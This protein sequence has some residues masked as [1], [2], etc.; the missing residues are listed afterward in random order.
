MT[1]TSLSHVLY[2]SNRV[3]TLLFF[4]SSLITL[5][6]YL[7]EN[8]YL[9]NTSVIGMLFLY[10][11]ALI[12]SNTSV[13]FIA[14]I[15]MQLLVLF[16]ASFVAIPKVVLDIPI[17]IISLFVFNRAVIKKNLIVPNKT[18]FSCLIFGI[19]LGHASYM[20]MIINNNDYE[21]MF[22]KT[23]EDAF[24][25]SD[26]KNITNS[27]Y[28][29][30]FNNHDTYN[31]TMLEYYEL[32]DSIK[33][34]NMREGISLKVQHFGTD[35]KLQMTNTMKVCNYST[36]HNI[37]CIISAYKDNLH[38]YNTYVYTND[39]IENKHL[40]GF[41]VTIDIYNKNTVRHR[42]NSILNNGGFV[43][44][45]KGGWYSSDKYITNY[46]WKQVTNEYIDVANSLST[47]N[48][49]HIIATHDYY[50]RKKINIGNNTWGIFSSSFPKHHQ[51]NTAVGIFYG[52]VIIKDISK[53]NLLLRIL[54][55]RTYGF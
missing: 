54:S 38:E 36:F 5:L 17:F 19:L 39:N 12:T 40:L 25:W 2:K 15:V 33:K 16:N 13:L 3:L 20:A 42:I 49:K 8:V 32:I 29:Y 47:S 43:R 52:D 21:S 27:Y 50:S 24:A 23:K 55:L 10:L 37:P 45:V 26:T 22:L 14:F 41:C 1:G 51:E 53:T 28:T 9:Y 18:L 11:Y 48:S 35:Y 44:L 34:R 31:K 6:L 46:H 7:T 30:Y 4:T